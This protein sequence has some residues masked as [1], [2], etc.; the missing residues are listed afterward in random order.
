MMLLTAYLPAS[1]IGSLPAG[2][3]SHKVKCSSLK[4][5]DV[6]A[7]STETMLIFMDKSVFSGTWRQ[8]KLI[9]ICAL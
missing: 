9:H 1:T 3:S 8:R 4:E 5:G 6:L 2:D 7:P